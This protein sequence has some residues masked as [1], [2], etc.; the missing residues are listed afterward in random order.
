MPSFV[1]NK[2]DLQLLTCLF[3]EKLASEMEKLGLP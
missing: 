1:C 2:P 3:V